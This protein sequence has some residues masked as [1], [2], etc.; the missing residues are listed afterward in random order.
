MPLGKLIKINNYHITGV[1]TMPQ[2][3]GRMSMHGFNSPAP[4]KLSMQN[5]RL[6]T[7]VY[8]KCRQHDPQENKLS[9]ARC[10]RIAWK[11]V[12]KVGRR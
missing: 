1:D 7:R 6:L 10:A 8:A 4:G 3:K 11:V 2:I 12:K 5:K 9:K